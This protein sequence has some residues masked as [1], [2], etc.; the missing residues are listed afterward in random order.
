MGPERLELS[1]IAAPDPKSGASTN[2][3]TGPLIYLIVKDILFNLGCVVNVLTICA[4]ATSQK[5]YLI[6]FSAEC[7]RPIDISKLSQNY[8]FV[9][10]F[11]I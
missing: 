10:I 5:R 9:N 1:H 8:I 7:H 3:A 6:V 11:V 4:S 2:F